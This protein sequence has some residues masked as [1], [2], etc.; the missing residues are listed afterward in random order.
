METEE[1]LLGGTC[2]I[3]LVFY[4]SPVTANSSRL[5]YRIQ[6]AGVP[7][8]MAKTLK[9][10]PVWKDHI[11]SR[12]A[13]L[14]GDMMF[15]NRQ[16]SQI[17][18]GQLSFKDYFTPAACD[19][20]VR[21]LWKHLSKHSRDGVNYYP[22]VADTNPKARE[23]ALDRYSQHVE[24]C[25]HCTRALERVRGGIAAAA[26][27]GFAGLLSALVCVVRGGWWGAPVACLAG[28]VAAAVAWQKLKSLEK[29]F[30]YEPYIHQEK[31]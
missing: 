26:A 15:L 13:I 21:E 3:S 29:K 23:V 25:V 20:G 2:R 28:V 10:Q 19:M 6:V 12:S 8:K 27:V 30:T 16:S 18:N 4:P 11:F 22:H 7:E 14:D 9:S 1:E 5:I 17:I 31:N 24:S